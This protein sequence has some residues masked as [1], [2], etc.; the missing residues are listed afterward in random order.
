MVVATRTNGDLFYRTTYDDGATWSTNPAVF[1]DTDG[2]QTVYAQIVEI[3]SG[4]LAIV[5]G[6]EFT[7]EASI[8]F[9]YLYDNQLPDPFA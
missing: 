3:R 7:D 8:R 2:T 6:T 5:W 1:I 4:E 9:S